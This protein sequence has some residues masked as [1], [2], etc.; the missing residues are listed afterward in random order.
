MPNIRNPFL[1]VHFTKSVH[2]EVYL[3]PTAIP[4]F[5]RE[6]YGILKGLERES[7]EIVCRDVRLFLKNENFRDLALEETRKYSF[8]YFFEDA[9]KL[10]RELHPSDIENSSKVGIRPQ[11]VDL[12]KN[13]LIMDFL[14]QKD[15][16]SIH[17]LNS[18]SPGFTSSMYFAEMVVGEYFG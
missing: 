13:E 11:L 6:N 12:K 9:K 10:V 4:A 1:G 5:G 7:I 17:I 3:G 15:K 16:R 2:G 8:K 18:I 14:I